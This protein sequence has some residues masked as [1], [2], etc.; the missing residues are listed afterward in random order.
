VLR[1]V[2]AVDVRLDEAQQDVLIAREQALRLDPQH[3][4]GAPA[5][6]A[7]QLHRVVAAGDRE[8]NG[9][10][11]AGLDAADGGEAEAAEAELQQLPGD[12]G[13]ARR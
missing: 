4:G 1:L 3:A 11:L 8:T 13:R 10:G 2:V 7:A 5:H 9:D 6:G 12:E